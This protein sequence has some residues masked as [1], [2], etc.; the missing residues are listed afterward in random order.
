VVL[1]APR[2]AGRE[3][4]AEE[5]EL[6]VLGMA[7][8]RPPAP[9]GGLPA[10]EP[11]RARIAAVEVRARTS[12]GVPTPCGVEHVLARRLANLHL[13]V[14]GQRQR[15]GGHERLP[16]HEVCRARVEPSD[17]LPRDHTTAP[18]KA[19]GLEHPERPTDGPPR[20]EHQKIARV[21]RRLSPYSGSTS[22]PSGVASN[23]ARPMCFPAM[24]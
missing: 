24:R 15:R 10:H 8:V 18:S 14:A 12:P 3:L 4:D 7:V 23:E 11:E 9:R 5:R 20:V 1:E 21:R 16:D 19:V 17:D 13:V 2:L 22:I 6:I